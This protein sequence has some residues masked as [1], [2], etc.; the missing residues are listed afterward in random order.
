ML[1]Q[2]S[3]PQERGRDYR[4]TRRNTR[5]ARDTPSNVGHTPAPQMTTTPGVL[6]RLSFAR[7]LFE[8]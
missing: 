4:D 1:A 7:V 5:H 8:R 2:A 3:T 6:P